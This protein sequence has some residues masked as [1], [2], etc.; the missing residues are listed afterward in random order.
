MRENY[1]KHF[2]F[3]VCFGTFYFNNF[4]QHDFWT[5]LSGLNMPSH[6]MS[7]AKSRRGRKR[8]LGADRRMEGFGT[9]RLLSYLLLQTHVPFADLRSFTSSDR[10]HKKRTNAKP[11]VVPGRWKCFAPEACHLHYCISKNARQKPISTISISIINF[12]HPSCFVYTYLSE[13]GATYLVLYLLKTDTE[14]TK[15]W[16]KYWFYT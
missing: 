16:I 7:S 15:V 11:P 8:P 10:K 9:D 1:Q 12:G 14:V 13:S 6:C 5:H 2:T 3:W 4:T